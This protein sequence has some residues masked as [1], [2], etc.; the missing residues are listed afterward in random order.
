MSPKII[1]GVIATGIAIYALRK[2]LSPTDQSEL[3]QSQEQP[4]TPATLA[5]TVIPATEVKTVTVGTPAIEVA[6]L[7]PTPKTEIVQ[8]IT[9]SLPPNKGLIIAILL[10]STFNGLDLMRK[11]SKKTKET[12]LAYQRF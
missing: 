9:P 1:T 5:T 2:K 12:I 8:K 4:G 6:P 11:H 3:V 10:H 7:L